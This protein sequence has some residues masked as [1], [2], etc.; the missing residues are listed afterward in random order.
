MVTGAVRGD[1]DGVEEM[2]TRCGD[3][4]V[5]WRGMAEAVVLAVIGWPEVGRRFLDA[6]QVRQASNSPEKNMFKK[7]QHKVDE[8]IGDEGDDGVG[9]SVVGVAFGG[10]GIDE[11]VMVAIV[12]HWEWWVIAWRMGDDVGGGGRLLEWPEVARN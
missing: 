11:V 1:D 6:H 3:D 8:F 10:G 2:V 4:V 9:G 5:R 7:C 12:W